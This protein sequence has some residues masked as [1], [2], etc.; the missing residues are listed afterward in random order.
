[1]LGDCLEFYKWNAAWIYLITN[2]EIINI[3]ALF[4]ATFFSLSLSLCLFGKEFYSS[5][6]RSHIS[7]A[8]S[9]CIAI[10]NNNINNSIQ[11]E[12]INFSI[13]QRDLSSIEQIIELMMI[14]NVFDILPKITVDGWMVYSAC[15]CIWACGHHNSLRNT[16]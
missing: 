14:V 1:M 16:S 5:L 15:K 2:S 11:S 7:H 6:S 3:N 10:H 4:L 8:R 9:N 13:I 12:P